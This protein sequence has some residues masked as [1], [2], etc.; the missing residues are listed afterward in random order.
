MNPLDLAK[1]LPQV[2][3]EMLLIL[4]KL[5]SSVEIVEYKPEVFPISVDKENSV[6]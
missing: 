4:A 3:P 5:I 2:R 6:F 1:L